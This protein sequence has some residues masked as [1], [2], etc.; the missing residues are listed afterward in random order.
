[1]TKEGNRE[2]REIRKIFEKIYIREA[3]IKMTLQ[4]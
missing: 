3:D 1:M 2:N 4:K